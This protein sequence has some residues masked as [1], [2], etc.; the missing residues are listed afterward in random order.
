MF[1]NR[2]KPSNKKDNNTKIIESLTEELL[3]RDHTISVLTDILKSEEERYKE[4]SNY[5]KSLETMNA[6]ILESLE[7]AGIDISSLGNNK[8]S[9][10]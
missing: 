8:K 3:S 7:E 4:L 9:D 1:F 5:A 2:K 6:D 10:A